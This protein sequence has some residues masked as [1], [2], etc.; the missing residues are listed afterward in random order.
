MRHY[1]LIRRPLLALLALAALAALFAAAAP[2]A[3]QEPGVIDGDVPPEGFALLTV[4][5]ASSPEQVVDALREQACEPVSL[6]ITEGGEFVT[7]IPG[8][9]DFVNAAF[10][11]DLP[12]GQPFAVL[13]GAAQVGGAFAS[14]P[15]DETDRE[16]A[17]VISD[18]RIASHE[19]FDRF[20]LEFTDEL[21]TGGID[22][23]DS[24][25][26]YSVEFIEL[27]EAQECGS[28][29][30]AEAEGNAFLRVTLPRGYVYNPETGQG[31]VEPLEITTDY[32]VVREAEEI[33]GFEGMSVWLI[34]VESEQPFRIAELAGPA[35]LVI[36]IQAP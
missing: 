15:V 3:A 33:C 24:V 31:T 22:L 29:F 4:E 10:P 6:A 7:Y 17:G 18:V 11:E 27:S 13:C 30:Q 5:T 9:P 16:G 25:P 2:A 21:D 12:Q 34:G 8:A 19:G 32:Q 20:V 1:T 35:R 36:D 28:G 26:G 14:D 23:A